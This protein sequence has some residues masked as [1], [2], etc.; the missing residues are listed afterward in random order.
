MYALYTLGKEGDFMYEKWIDDVYATLIGVQEEGVP[1][2][3]N[4]FA[5]GEYCAR[6]YEDMTAHRQRLWERLGCEDDEDIEQILCAMESI[7]AELCRKMF[8]YGMK[9]GNAETK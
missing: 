4:A 7:Q 3:E 8:E 1:G 6:R 2:V 5:P 9:F